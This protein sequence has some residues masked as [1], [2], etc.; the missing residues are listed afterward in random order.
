MLNTYTSNVTNI[1]YI[2]YV[3]Q[4][5]LGIHTHQSIHPNW[6]AKFRYT[7]LKL[8][9]SATLRAR[10]PVLTILTLVASAPTSY[11]QLWLEPRWLHKY[12]L[13]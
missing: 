8:F 4:K 6:C 1:K 12:I 13:Q 5:A 2:A 7:C 9:L 10:A 11:G 3:S